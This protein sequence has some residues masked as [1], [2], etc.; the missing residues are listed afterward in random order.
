VSLWSTVQVVTIASMLHRGH[1]TIHRNGQFVVDTGTGRFNLH[2][3]EDCTFVRNF[4][5]G[6]PIRRHPKQVTFG[7]N[8]QVVVGGSDHGIVHVFDRMTG[9]KLAEL[10]A[11]D[12]GM[13]QTV[14]VRPPKYSARATGDGML[15]THSREGIHTI[16]AAT[17]N[18]RMPSTIKVWVYKAAPPMIATTSRT[19]EIFDRLV[20]IV[21]LFAAIIFVVVNFDHMVSNCI[22]MG[23]ELNSQKTAE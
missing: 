10:R 12:G 2:E 9:N 17:S 5:T 6:T 15:Q 21:L 3:L 13:V 18:M 1:A 16:V 19:K 7:E 8:G 4:P 11:A 20:N 23:F 22:P 14:M